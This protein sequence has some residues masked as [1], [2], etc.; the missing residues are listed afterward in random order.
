MKENTNLER[1]TPSNVYSSTVYNIQDM[2]ANNYPSI[3]EQIKRCDTYIAERSLSHKKTGTLSCAA[4][5][6]VCIMI[7]E[8]SQRTNT[9]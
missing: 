3:D 6:M 1:Y 8:I 5:G 7:S 4:T 9:V 2:E